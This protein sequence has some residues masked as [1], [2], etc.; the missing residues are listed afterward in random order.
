MIRYDPNPK[1]CIEISPIKL[2]KRAE[3]QVENLPTGCESAYPTVPKN[4]PVVKTMAFGIIVGL[5][6][7][8]IA[9]TG[10]IIIMLPAI[11]VPKNIFREKLLIATCFATPFTSTAVSKVGLANENPITPTRDV[12]IPAIP[13]NEET[14]DDDAS[15]EAPRIV[16]PNSP[17]EV[18]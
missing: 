5:T 6:E 12:A 11:N 13:K 15:K 4:S 14:K 3:P 1:S 7:F 16:D 8:T 17:N 9:K 10:L 18:K 2:P